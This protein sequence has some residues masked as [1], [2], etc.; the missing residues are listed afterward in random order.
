MKDCKV[1]KMFHPLTL[2]MFFTMG[3]PIST[4]VGNIFRTRADIEVNRAYIVL[5]QSEFF[6]ENFTFGSIR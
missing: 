1:F 5:G 4:L 3:S 6:E 2:T